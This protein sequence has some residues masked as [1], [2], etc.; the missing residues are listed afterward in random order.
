MLSRL[1]LILLTSASYLW[2]QSFDAHLHRFHQ[3][4]L[5]DGQKHELSINIS[6]EFQS[7][8]TDIS[9]TPGLEEIEVKTLLGKKDVEFFI[10]NLFK[11]PY[12]IPLFCHNLKVLDLD[13]LWELNDFEIRDKCASA[14]EKLLE[15]LSTGH[16]VLRSFKLY[17]EGR[18]GNYFKARFMAENPQDQTSILINFDVVVD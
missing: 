17:G 3:H 12:V 9:Q 16:F 14:I 7:V 5:G 15:P 1:F 2:A 8:L 4:V 18:E 6:R 10:S 11:T 13:G